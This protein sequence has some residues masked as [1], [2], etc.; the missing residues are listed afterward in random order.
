MDAPFD[1][2]LD[3]DTDIQD[4]EDFDDVYHWPEGAPGPQTVAQI[5]NAQEN[6]CLPE[7]GA[8]SSAL[9][10]TANILVRCYS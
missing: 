1:M 2:I 8:L 5:S 6:D 3:S 4:V 7:D 9:D 10:G